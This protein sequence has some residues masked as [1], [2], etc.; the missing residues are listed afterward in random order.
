[1]L[2]GFFYKPYYSIFLQIMQVFAFLLT[3]KKGFNMTL[4]NRLILNDGFNSELADGAKFERF[5]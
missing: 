5:I 3:L 4:K 1:M 2:T